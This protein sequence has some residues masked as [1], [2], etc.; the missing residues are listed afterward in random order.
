MALIKAGQVAWCRNTPEIRSTWRIPKERAYFCI[1]MERVK[2][3][4]VCIRGFLAIGPANIFG[5]AKIHASRKCLVWLKMGCILLGQK[6]FYGATQGMGKVSW[7]LLRLGMTEYLTAFGK[8]NQTK[9][10]DSHLALGSLVLGAI[11][12]LVLWSSGRRVLGPVPCLSRETKTWR[13]IASSL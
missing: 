7:T 12:L 11:L 4:C 10:P 6:G 3:E 5:R 2:E 13:C 9:R 1:C 8:G